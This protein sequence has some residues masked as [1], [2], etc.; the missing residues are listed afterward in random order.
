MLVIKFLIIIIFF[1]YVLCVSNLSSYL[2]GGWNA[3]E[4]PR[5]IF[6]IYLE[7]FSISN[8]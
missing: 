8:I 2:F 7:L 6:Q 3:N 5:R 1:N 4:C